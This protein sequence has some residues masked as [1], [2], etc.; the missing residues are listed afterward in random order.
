MNYSEL[1]YFVIIDCKS[2]TFISFRQK[3][4][5]KNHNFTFIFHFLIFFRFD[6]A[7]PVK[8]QFSHLFT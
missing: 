1:Y 6:F 2:I 5:N 7:S 4:Y 3:N 8:G